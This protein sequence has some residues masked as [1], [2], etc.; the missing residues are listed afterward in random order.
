MNKQC[1]DCLAKDKEIEQLLEIIANLRN[2][3]AE[4]RGEEQIWKPND[5]RTT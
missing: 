5:W 1:S 2:K 4:A 3:L